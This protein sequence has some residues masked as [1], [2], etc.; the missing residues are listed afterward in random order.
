[1][2]PRLLERIR[3]AKPDAPKTAENTDALIASIERHLELILNTH[4]GSSASAPDF[5]MPDFVS[6]AGET[7]LDSLR[8]LS[9]VLTEVVRRYEPR[10]TNPVVTHSAASQETGVL[11]FSLSGVIEFRDESR[12]LF[13]STSINP[14]G[15]IVVT[16]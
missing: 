13:F 7:G 5:G 2:R 14:D 4:Q 6:L 10:L 8:E 16:K 9:S 15:R 3:A 12:G 1:L 11:E